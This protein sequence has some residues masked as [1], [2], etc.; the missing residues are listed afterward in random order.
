M[1]LKNEKLT[2]KINKHYYLQFQ[3]IM[4]IIKLKLIDFMVYTKKAFMHSLK[5][6]IKRSGKNIV[7]QT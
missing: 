5:I 2:L 1:T 6:S 7:C 4:A 3:A